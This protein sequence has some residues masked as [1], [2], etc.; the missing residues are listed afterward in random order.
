MT[1]TTAIKVPAPVPGVPL[2]KGA[3]AWPGML[4]GALLETYRKGFATFWAAPAIVA[5]VVVPEATQHVIEIE[6]GMFASKAAF[7]ANAS[8]PLRM[9]IGAVK[10]AALLLCILATARFWS[11]GSVRAA[12]L[13]P[14]R[15]LGRTLFALALGFAASLPA[16]W[17]VATK[18]PLAVYWTI[19]PA[20][21][22]LS[23]LL[24]VYLIGAVLG[25][26]AMTLRNALTHGWKVLPLLALL[27]VSAFWPASML[28]AYAHK[29]ALGAA[30]LSVWALMA[31]DSLVVG[32]MATVTGSALAVS[33]RLGS[34]AAAK[35]P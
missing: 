28:H 17:A 29:L 25:D 2:L 3:V 26:R 24:L 33:Y 27:V 11:G 5:I 4:L 23:F 13:I 35:A 16:E 21:W 22:L 15:D 9:G 14:P 30:P 6:L 1:T 18:Q 10:V 12:L 31:A 32:L 19:V 8:D 34:G 20:S 7:I